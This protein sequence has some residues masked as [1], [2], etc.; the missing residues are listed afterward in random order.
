LA[1]AKAADEPSAAGLAATTSYFAGEAYGP[2]G[3]LLASVTLTGGDGYVI[4]AELIAWGAQ[5]A[6]RGGIAGA[7]ALDPV[8]A[9][10]LTSLNEGAEQATL[11]RQT[12]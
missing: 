8:R 10:G 6:L 4:T 12:P 3:E 2:S 1:A 7:G 5:Q 9:F 11:K